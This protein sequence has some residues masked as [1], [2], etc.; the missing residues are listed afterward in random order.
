MPLVTD[1]LKSMDVPFEIL[2]HQ[3]TFHACDEADRLGIPLAEVVKTVLIET[4][5]GHALA[6]IPASRRLDMHLVHRAIGDPHARLA[7]EA[8]ILRRFPNYEP[9]ALPPMA[10]LLQIPVLID[11]EVVSRDTVVFATSECESVR[12]STYGLLAGE[13]FKLA[14]LVERPLTPT[15]VAV[16]EE[17]ELRASTEADEAIGLMADPVS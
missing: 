15:L 16:A 14:A 10:S 1:V 2:F 13:A 9:G 4:P 5:S 7:T 3:P 8:E 17:V 6:V 12:V 11:P